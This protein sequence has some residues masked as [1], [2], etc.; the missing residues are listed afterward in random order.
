MARLHATLH[1]RR[2]R[3]HARLDGE[4]L[5]LGGVASFGAARPRRARHARAA[6][7]HARRR[8]R[9]RQSGGAARLRLG[10]DGRWRT[11]GLQVGAAPTS[12]CARRADAAAAGV[13]PGARRRTSSGTGRRHL[14]GMR[15]RSG[16]GELDVDG[17]M[18]REG[19]RRDAAAA[20]R[21][22]RGAQPRRRKAG[23]AAAG[24]LVGQAST[25]PARCRRRSSRP[26]STRA[27]TRPW[28]GSASASTRC[29]CAPSPTRA[30]PS[31]TPMR[32]GAT[33]RAW[34]STCTAPP[35][36]E[37]EQLHRRRRHARPR[38]DL[39]ARPHLAL[40]RAVRASSRR[41]A[42][43]RRRLPAGRARP[44]RDCARRQ[45]AAP[46][47]APDALDVT[48]T[49]RHLDLRDLHALLAPGH[50]EPPKT[51]FEIHAHVAG[52]R[53]APVVDVQL[54]GRGSE[55]DEGGLPEN[56]ELPHQRALGP[57]AR[58][59]PGVDAA[60]RHAARHR[61]HVRRADRARHGEQPICARA[62][63]AAGA[64]LQ[65]SPSLPTAI[66]EP[67]RASSRCA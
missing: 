19:M 57:S 26:R 5:A 66:A 22:S 53:R 1:S 32:A 56:V 18:A 48:L 52:T 6:R 23:P 63:G 51:D 2:A 21:R 11:D 39:G 27:P 4:R 3:R 49:T 8:A 47:A 36:S 41:R 14:A 13:A 25:S 46:A 34:S 35:R 43:R 20:R 64:V 40:A 28:P 10:A 67:R 12:W 37:G 30:T 50:R 54:A 16:V 9:R 33:T 29:R 7:G 24:A 61:R 55:M 58:A 15:V 45:R 60:G 42:R 31:C 65:D 44:R 59:R 62:R 38:A 17:R